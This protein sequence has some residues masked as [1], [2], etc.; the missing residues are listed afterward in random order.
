MNTHLRGRAAVAVAAVACVALLGAC[1]NET[2]SVPS[3]TTD[4]SSTSTASTTAAPSTTTVTT[5]VPA[6]VTTVPTT[7]KTVTTAPS[8]TK[9][10]ARYLVRWQSPSRNIACMGSPNDTGRLTVKCQ[11]AQKNYLRPAGAKYCD[12]AGT[13]DNA[14]AL[15]PGERADWLCAS[16][17]WGGPYVP[18]LGYGERNRIGSVECMSVSSGMSCRDMSAGGS[19]F[20]SRAYARVG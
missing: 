1:Q 9:P 19:F 12:G 14:V 15:T 7:T 11:I 6:P 17:Y 4:A 8:A 13:G 10:P 3:S 16:D 5:T 2:V 18:V 20:L